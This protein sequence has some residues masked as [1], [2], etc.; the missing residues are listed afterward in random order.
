MNASVLWI[1]MLKTDK[2][3]QNTY[4]HFAPAHSNIIGNELSDQRAKIAIN[5]FKDEEQNKVTITLINL[6][7]HLRIKTPE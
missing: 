2:F 7:T 3:A 4:L 6:K 5:D 1:K